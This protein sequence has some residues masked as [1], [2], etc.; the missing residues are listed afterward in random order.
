MSFIERRAMGHP[1]A[2]EVW[3]H[4]AFMIREDRVSGHARFV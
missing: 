1:Q 3:S 4:L 2:P